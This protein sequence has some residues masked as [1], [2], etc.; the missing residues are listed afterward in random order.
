MRLVIT[1]YR[2][3]ITV[4][5]SNPLINIML[6][7]HM[8]PTPNVVGKH[9]C[10]NCAMQELRLALDPIVSWTRGTFGACIMLDVAFMGLHVGQ[11][12]SREDM[13]WCFQPVTE[14]SA[15]I[16]G[17]DGYGIA[18]GWQASTS[19]KHKTALRLRLRAH[20]INM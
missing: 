5:C 10:A 15:K 20:R 18:V 9:G 7:G 4:C 3:R 2:S 8:I 6:Q 11:L 12:S 1:D 13:A 19:Y 16:M 14:N 17:L